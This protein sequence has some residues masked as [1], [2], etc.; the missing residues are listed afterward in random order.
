M[1]TACTQIRTLLPP[2]PWLPF[3]FRDAR[4]DYGL[5]LWSG[6]LAEWRRSIENVQRK[7]MSDCE[8]RLKEVVDK[9]ERHRMDLTASNNE[10][11]KVYNWLRDS[12]THE[13]VKVSAYP[14]TLKP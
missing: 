14:K 4:Y 3:H 11:K 5:D 6:L 9:H 1:K 13:C 10:A 7:Y 8:E 12:F 2:P